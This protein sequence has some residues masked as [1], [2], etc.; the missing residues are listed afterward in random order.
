[1]AMQ[2]VAV[3][4]LLALA[5]PLFVL[6]RPH[7]D[8]SPVCGY[9]SCPK[10]KPGFLNVH[11]VPHT[12]DDVGWLKT[13]DQYYYGSRSMTQKAGVQYIIDSVV[14]ELL[15]DPNKRF[16]YVE[17]AFFWKWWKNQHDTRR[18]QVKK[19]VESGRLEFI[20]GAWSMNDEAV[21]NYMSIID[22]FTWGLRKLNETFGQCARPRV[23]WQIDPFGHSRE[24]ASLFAQM[25]YD[26]LFFGRLDYQDKLHRLGAQQGEMVWRGSPNLGKAAELFTGVLYNTYSPPPGFC[27][28]VLCADDP[29]IDDKRSPDYNIVTK[30]KE[31]I[32]LA[33]VQAANY[34]TGNVIMTMGEDFQYQAADMWYLN[35]D[36]LI[37]YINNHQTAEEKVNLFYSTPSCYLKAVHDSNNTWT[38]KEDDFFPYASDPHA[39]WTGYYTSRPTIKY[40]ER[41][42]NNFLQVC[43]NL[44]ALADL[45]PE[46]M[47]DLDSMREAMGVMQHHDA[48]TGTEKQHV[49]DDYARLLTR[50]FDECGIATKAALNKLIRKN[51]VPRYSLDSSSSESDESVV[52]ADEKPAQVQDDDLLPFQSCLLLNQSQCAVSEKADKFVVTVYNTQ[53]QRTS[54]FVRIPVP[55]ATGYTVRCP[56]GHEEASQVLP[57]PEP[58]LRLPGRVMSTARYELVFKADNL[59]ALGF[60]SFYVSRDGK[61][62][63]HQRPRAAEGA[64]ALF[65]GNEHLRVEL[66]EATGRVRNLRVGGANLSVAQ[67]FL[68]YPAMVGNNEEFRNRSSGAYIFRPNGTALP[69]SEK[70]TMKV[71]K[72]ALVQEVH[73]VFNEWV[74]QVIRI[75]AG[76]KH[77]ELDWLVGP[78]PVDDLVGKEVISRISTNLDTKGVFYTDS[79]GRE[80][81]KRQRNFRPT[82]KV[83]ISEPVAGNYYPVTSKIS[84]RDPVKKQSVAVIV[85]RAQGGSSLQ[86]GEMELMVH[87]RLLHDD[88]FGVDEALNEEAFG[89]GLVARGTHYVLGG[90]DGEAVG[91]RSLSGQ[92]RILAQKKLVQPWTFFTALDKDMT[93]DKWH[94]TYNMEFSGLKKSLPHNVHVL[95]LEPWK[96]KSLLLRLEHFVEKGE[97]HELSKEVTVNVQDMLTPFKILRLRE[98][99]L[100]ANHWLKDSQRLKWRSESNDIDQGEEEMHAQE[101][102]DFVVK[103]TPMQIRTFVIDINN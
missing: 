36:K 94:K 96:G 58:V 76:E 64:D 10:A 11:L 85:D 66:D 99:T 90:A 88:A 91:R 29:I 5:A 22:Q 14:N 79:N 28:D 86:D 97:D 95:T 30:A 42:G 12:H 44:Y 101:E 43:K 6:G 54:Q 49:A 40:F 38:T 23:G 50:G 20:G 68:Y 8:K 59:P 15:H 17:T 67:D 24:Q 55:E 48:I 7:E 98:T 74:S 31:F 57:I 45:G 100:G 16:I 83:M 35:L 72:G 21:T 93:F 63:E 19:L 84:V 80:M 92:E 41:L 53:S 75:Y 33:R 9:D 71:Y 32:A 51:S 89:T 60:R 13:V 78:V 61:R 69:V 52:V 87:R 27:F 70:A 62:H 77:V 18:H 73:Q 3:V 25:G 34:T 46:D 103:L 47:A 81:L 37:R 102:T 39:Y 65:V 4:A 82:W 1:M 56:M 26:G 2:R